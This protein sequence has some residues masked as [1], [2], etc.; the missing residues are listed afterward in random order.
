MPCP[1]FASAYDRAVARL[2][3]TRLQ[4]IY[5]LSDITRMII[6]SRPTIAE[7]RELIAKVD[8]QFRKEIV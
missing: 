4:N 2:E 6:L 5:V 7:S 8:R 3:A 1:S